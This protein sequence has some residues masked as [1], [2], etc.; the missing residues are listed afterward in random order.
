MLKRMRVKHDNK[1][2]II[3]CNKQ[4][5]ES[6]TSNSKVVPGFLRYLSFQMMAL[7]RIFFQNTFMI[8]SSLKIHSECQPVWIQ[9]RPDIVSGLILAKKCFHSSSA[10]DTCR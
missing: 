7:S 6:I 10:D 9:I 1:Q 4:V 8:W 3:F 2:K 5:L